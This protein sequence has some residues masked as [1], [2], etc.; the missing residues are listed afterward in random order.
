MILMDTDVIIWILRGDETVSSAFKKIVSDTEGQVYFTPVQS[1]EI[2]AGIREKEELK[3][4]R[5]FSS[6][7]CI[8]IDTDAGRLAGG[9]MKQYRKSH[10][11]T[12]ADALV[13]ACSRVN[14]LKLWTIN[15]KRYPMLEEGEFVSSTI[16]AEST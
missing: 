8:A 16:E 15:K 10:N 1:A 7:N 12:L 2:Y 11:V 5:F 14:N 4:E 9:F 3:V 13:A 6:L